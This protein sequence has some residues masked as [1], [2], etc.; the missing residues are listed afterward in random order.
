MSTNDGVKQMNWT[1]RIRSFLR[2]TDELKVVLEASWVPAS[3]STTGIVAPSPSYARKRNQVQS[4]SRSSSITRALSGPLSRSSSRA[5]HSR[6]ASDTGRITPQANESGSVSVEMS[7]DEQ[8]PGNFNVKRVDESPV[9]RRV[10]AVVSHK[11]DWDLTEEGCVLIFQSRSPSTV[12]VVDDLELH[13][14]LPIYGAFAIVMSQMQRRSTIDMRTLNSSSGSVDLGAGTS[15][16]SLAITP[17]EGLSSATRTGNQEGGDTKTKPELFYVRDAHEELREFVKECKRLKEEAESHIEP[18]SYSGISLVATSAALTA[19][20]TNFAWLRPYVLHMHKEI[21]FVLRSR[22]PPDLRLA[23]LPMNE[24]LSN[25][26]AGGGLTGPAGNEGRERGDLEVLRDVWVRCEAREEALEGCTSKSQKLRIRIGTFN[27]NGKLPSQDLSTWVQGGVP[28]TP[29]TTTNLPQITTVSPLSIGE[30]TNGGGKDAEVNPFDAAPRNA[31]SSEE[32]VGLEPILLVLGFQELDLSTEALIYNT[33]PAKEDA[34]VTA[35]IAG[36]G[37]RGE[38]WEKVASKQ[39]V[40]MLIVILVKKEHRSNFGDIQSIS[41]GTGVM[42]VMGNKGASAIRVSYYPAPPSHEENRKQRKMKP[43]ILTFVNAHL[44]AFDDMVDKRNADY[45]E[46]TRRLRFNAPT[47][48]IRPQSHPNSSAEDSESQGPVNG[49]P[50]EPGEKEEE[51]DEEPEDEEVEAAET[52]SVFESDALFWL[53][54]LNYRIDIP[55]IPLRRILRDQEWDNVQKFETLKRFDQLQKAMEQKKAFVGF[56]ESNITHLPTYR[57]SPGLGMDALGYDLK[58]KPAWTDR[59]LY[60]P[61]PACRITQLSYRGVP[62]VTMSDHRPVVG[63]F[64]LEVDTIGQTVYNQ[65]LRRLYREVD[66]LEVSHERKGLVLNT[67]NLDF[68]KI[69]YGSS[70]ARNVKVSNASKGPCAFRFVPVQMD[71]PVHPEWL[72]IEPQTGILRPNESITIT[73][74]AQ[75]PLPLATTLNKQAVTSVDLSGTLILHTLLGK[76]HFITLSA[77]WEPTCF[78]NSLS[79]LTQLPCPIRKLGSSTSQVD[80]SGEG[81]EKVQ[82][83][84]EKHRKNAPSEVIRLINWLMTFSSEGSVKD[85]FLQTADDALVDQLRECLDT[86]VDFP[87]EPVPESEVAARAVSV[88][89]MKLLDSLPDPVIPGILHPQCI[90]MANRDEAFELLDA[91]QPAAVNVWISL[92]AFLHYLSNTSGREN[93]AEQLASVWAPIL[94]RD[95][96][97]S[98]SPPISPGQKRNFLLYFIT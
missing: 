84:D 76:D 80:G 61:S 79:F 88:L 14:V 21:P 83:M 15:G 44:A 6:N 71:G 46:L 22:I 38:E 87:Y 24:R 12:S 13:R 53:G 70:E 98:F 40:G 93:H 81:P 9:H 36:L 1:S 5:G 28:E 3:S 16:F 59:I 19:S 66:H 10:L 8:E 78:A 82:L 37:E 57:F 18:S 65:A 41:A 60:I 49:G 34:W 7:G 55:D 85:L 63:D 90:E 74:K 11:D 30:I 33:G 32:Q 42:G 91:V 51:S 89:L 64:A 75:V 96:P 29:Q 39:L 72:K 45:R 52:T 48:S 58:R 26:S 27:V 73:L 20:T 94:M 92:T 69:R 35:C 43:V 23:S 31:P 62:Q 2:S 67:P 77:E 17:A 95:D 50:V 86:G 25:T 68:G 56:K 47:R 97:S 4:I 54:D